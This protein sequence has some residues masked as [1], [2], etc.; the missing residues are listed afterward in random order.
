MIKK[1]LNKTF[2]FSFALVASAIIFIASVGQ[3]G[4]THV[5][6]TSGCSCH[7]AS[8][9]CVMT[10]TGPDTIIVNT[11]NTYTIS[12]SGSGSSLGGSA[13]DIATN[14]GKISTTDAKLKTSGSAGTELVMTG[15]RKTVATGTTYV[16]NITAPATAGAGKICATGMWCNGSGSSG[17]NWADAPDKAITVVLGT[18][19]V[20]ENGLKKFDYS[21]EQNFP[22]PFNPS[23][24]INYSLG[25]SG[26]VMLKVYDITGKE[27]STLVNQFQN[28]GVHSVSFDASKMNS[29][30]YL[31]TIS[32]GSF[33]QTRKMV[34]NK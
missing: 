4:R 12:F 33:S 7:T 3:S 27:V 20:N 22:N 10:I 18:T 6:S 5:S 16:V 30:V 31:Y 21:I 2:L 1:L 29:G 32:S 11:V 17:D 19:A 13:V 24:S 34:L 28:A 23:T 8:A 26:N 9:N 25:V 15:S 14:I